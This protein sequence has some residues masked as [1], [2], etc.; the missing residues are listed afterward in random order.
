MKQTVQIIR[1]KQNLYLAKTGGVLALREGDETYNNFNRELITAVK[2]VYGSAF[3]G[4]INHYGEQRKR[5]ADG[6]ESVYTEY[7]E[8]PIYNFS[9]DFVIPVKDECLETLI[10]EW[11]CAGGYA[12]SGN[13]ISDIQNRVEKLGG[14]NLIWF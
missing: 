7:K 14:I 4:S 9:C 8:Q 6:I 10:R 11:N 12:K 5:V 3:L 2:G 1:K 13:L